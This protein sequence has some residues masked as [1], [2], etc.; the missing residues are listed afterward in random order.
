MRLNVVAEYKNVRIRP[1]A[2]EDLEY[3]RG[4]RN[5]VA[6]GKF[7]RPIGEITS[8]MQ[9]KWYATECASTDSVTLAI[10]EI[11]ELNRLVGSLGIYNIKQDQAEIGRIIVG[12][13]DARGRKIGYHS[14]LLAM[15]IGFEK[16]G[17][18]K[19]LLDVH[20]DNIPAKISYSRVG[21]RA[22]G[23]HPFVNGGFEIE[24]EMCKE[25]FFQMHGDLRE[26]K[27]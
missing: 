8:D 2:E 6:L 22:K 25:Q 26:V 9:K 4:W 27:L 16:L 12:D 3:L 15:Y 19:Y 10:E 20:E 21:F 11:G 13:K 23:K 24:M 5:D 14:F 18:E 1:I 7:L 17:I